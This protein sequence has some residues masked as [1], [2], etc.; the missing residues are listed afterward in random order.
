MPTFLQV[1]GRDVTTHVSCRTPAS[2]RIRGNTSGLTNYVSLQLIRKRQQSLIAT[3][4][5][6]SVSVLFHSFLPPS[7]SPSCLFSYFLSPSSRSFPFYFPF[8]APP[9]LFFPSFSSTSF[10]LFADCCSLSS[11][12]FISFPFFPLYTFLSHSLPHIISFLPL[13]VFS[14]PHFFPFPCLSAPFFH[15]PSS[16]PPPFSLIAAHSV[17]CGDRVTPSDFVYNQRSRVFQTS[18]V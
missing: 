3:R 16:F 1:S 18:I 14:P 13:L 11:L 10:P 6:F 7:F 8:L 17:R 12:H 5:T 4:S 15:F 2:E 9:P